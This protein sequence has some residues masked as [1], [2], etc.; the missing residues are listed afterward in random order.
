MKSL[1]AIVGRP[2]VGKSTLFNR[3]V[4]YRKAIVEDT[5]GVTRDLNFAEVG[6]E[7]KAFTLVDTGGF[8]PGEEPVAAQV[9]KGC[10]WAIEE[11]DLVLFVLDGREGLTPL[12]EEICRLLREKGK[13][14]L[15]V[16]NKIDGPQHEKEVYDFYRLGVERLY[17][18]S[19][20]HGYRF[21]ELMEELLQALPSP[22]E[23]EE[24]GEEVRV[25]VVGRPNVGKSSLVN[26]ILGYERVI[27]D[28]RPGTT[29]DAIDTPFQWRGK[30]YLLIDTAGIRRR[31]RISLRLERYS[32]I[33]AIR[34]IERSDVSLLM[35]DA[36]EGVTEQDMRI[37]GLIERR[38]KGCV[39]LV[40]K[41]DL[42]QGKAKEGEYA[43]MVRRRLWFLDYAPLLFTSA[44]KGEGV[45]MVLEAVDR[46]AEEGKKRISTSELN[47]WMEGVLSSHSPPHWRG[48]PVKFYY[49]TQVGVR[50]PT[51]VFFVNR[52]QGVTAN[53]QRYLARRLREAFRFEGNPIR[54]IFRQRG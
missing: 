3:I 42:L 47:R 27:V 50:P 33:E 19:A 13:Q 8:E 31:S 43:E 36:Q 46:V 14:V 30:S 18:V 5:P 11:A 7:G 17:P 32:V 4:G 41:W 20:Q 45:G 10:Q 44:L 25:A 21:G 2:N 9:I 38:G 54:L 53:Y 48:R 6:I 22:P 24:K 12:D 34:S 26:A 35:I 49:L 37:G 52:P 51:F 23:E 29:R 40:N 16:V 1:V 39:L 15:Y 28:E